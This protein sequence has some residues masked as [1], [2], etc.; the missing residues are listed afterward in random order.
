M[1]KV[2]DVPC[3]G[4]QREDHPLL[5]ISAALT[6]AQQEARWRLARHLQSL[7]LTVHAI[8]KDSTAVA[9]FASVYPM[10][11]SL[12]IDQTIDYPIAS[13]APHTLGKLRRHWLVATL[14]SSK[15]TAGYVHAMPRKLYRHEQV[16]ERFFLFVAQAIAVSDLQLLFRQSNVSFACLHV[17]IIKAARARSYGWKTHT[18]EQ[19]H[20]C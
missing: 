7:C 20:C 11:S 10:L 16:W 17:R 13:G 1:F 14:A 19:R 12:R 3:S 2:L 4:S 9:K 18:A 5:F 15:G 8:P 6:P